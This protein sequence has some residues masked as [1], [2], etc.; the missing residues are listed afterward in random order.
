MIYFQ[1]LVLMMGRMS[2]VVAIS[3]V[4]AENV[5]VVWRPDNWIWVNAYGFQNPKTERVKQN[6]TYS[7]LGEPSLKASN[8]GEEPSH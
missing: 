6:H 2:R 3:I 7:V 5:I 4:L 8:Q 1:P